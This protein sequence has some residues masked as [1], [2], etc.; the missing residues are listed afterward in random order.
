MEIDLHGFE[1]AEAQIEVEYALREC[2]NNEDRELRI[3]HGY[4]SGN[5]L[6]SYF[7][8]RKFI[9][10]AKKLG[11]SLQRVGSKTPGDTSYRILP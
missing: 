6:K 5:V 4:R 9:A 7:Q 1:L 8:S 11:I 3:I 2:K 10:R